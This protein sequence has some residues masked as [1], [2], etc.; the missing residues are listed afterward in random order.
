M[1][2]IKKGDLFSSVTSSSNGWATVK[3]ERGEK[4]IVPDSYLECITDKVR[5]ALPILEPCTA[6]ERG[7]EGYYVGGDGGYSCIAQL[8]RFCYCVCRMRQDRLK[9]HRMS[10]CTTS[11]LRML[12]N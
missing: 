6:T 3:N 4:G 8:L 9:E 10:C 11:E 12:T 2:S 7:R 5:S 1:L